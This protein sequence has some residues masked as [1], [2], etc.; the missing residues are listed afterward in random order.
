M[1]I[2]EMEVEIMQLEH[3]EQS[4]LDDMKQEEFTL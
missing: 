4:L 2:Q 3:E 1:K